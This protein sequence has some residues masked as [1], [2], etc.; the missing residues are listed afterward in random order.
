MPKGGRGAA[1]PANAA[2]N[3]DDGAMKARSGVLVQIEDH[4]YG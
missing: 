4:V 3:D 2:E 1:G